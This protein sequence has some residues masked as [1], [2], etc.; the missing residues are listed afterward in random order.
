[1]KSKKRGTNLNPLNLV[2]PL[3]WLSKTQTLLKCCR[4]KIVLKSARI[5]ILKC[6]SNRQ[7]FRVSTHAPEQSS[8]TTVK[9]KL[10]SHKA[11]H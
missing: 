3:K 10:E 7:D 11:L 9:T 2:M 8:I 4:N 6:C 5:T 1:M